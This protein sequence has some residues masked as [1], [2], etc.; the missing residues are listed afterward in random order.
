MPES[1]RPAPSIATLTA[2]G[3]KARFG[4][5]YLRAVCSHAGVGFTEVSVDEDVL[6]IDGMINF[7]LAEV[8]VQVKCT[9]QFRINGGGTATW[10]A[11]DG[12]WEKWHRSGVPA[13]FVLVVLDPDDQAAWLHHHDEGTLHRAAAFWV[14]VDNMSVGPGITVPKTQ[15]LTAD[16]LRQWAE[17][18][19]ECF[20]P[21]GGGDRDGR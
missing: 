2:N 18:V 20:R 11:E 1:E 8:R 7:S 17:D 3:A 16:T 15:R 12:W 19:E 21:S 9:G 14:R 4:V 5:A 10:P 6:A 13:D